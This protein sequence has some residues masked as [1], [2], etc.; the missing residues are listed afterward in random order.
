MT[1]EVH[2][3]ENN[4]ASEKKVE[5]IKTLLES[6]DPAF[7]AQVAA[8]PD[9]VGFT[10]YGPFPSLFISVGHK[11]TEDGFLVSSNAD[12]PTLSGLVIQLTQH[13]PELV[14]HGAYCE[15]LDNTGV[16]Y[17][18]EARALKEQHIVLQ[19]LAIM[20]QRGLLDPETA[21]AQGSAIMTP[22]KQIVIAK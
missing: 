19:G 22:N 6:F 4:A 21:H 14:F 1:T 16:R 5:A 18:E 13:F 10:L 20:K 3:I 12:A 11:L 9:G 8:R 15:S 7:K 2:T 17:G